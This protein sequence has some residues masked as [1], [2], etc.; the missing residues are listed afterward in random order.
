MRGQNLDRQQARAASLIL[1][2]ITNSLSIGKHGFQ[3]RLI[4]FVGYHALTE[5]ALAR[6]R[7]RCQDVAGEGVS[8]SDFAGTRFL[9]AFGR[10]LMCLH[11]GHNLELLAESPKEPRKATHA[12]EAELLQRV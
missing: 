1:L 6:A 12:A 9:E 3:L 8:A 10:T 4:S 2:R 11:L 5:L 7:L